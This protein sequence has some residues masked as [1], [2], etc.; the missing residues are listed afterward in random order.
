LVN[1]RAIIF[2]MDGLLLDSERI[3]LN[4]FVEACRAH[5]FEPDLKVYY[6]CI[7]TVFAHTREILREGYGSEFPLESISAF[8]KNLYHEEITR[9]PVPLKQGAVELL[10]FLKIQKLPLAVVTSSRWQNAQMKLSMAGI[11]GY[12]TFILGGDQIS[13]GKP[14]PEI[15]LTACQRLNLEPARCLA[16]EDS[17]NGVRAAR[18]AGLHVIQV[19]D[20]LTPGEEIRNSGHTIVRSLVEVLDL[21]PG[22]LE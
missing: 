15:Y 12:F 7:G 19:P 22:V 18:S 14:D 21:L 4:T 17:D 9:K 16:L 5:G 11:A 10:D 20:I 6:R 3:S 13:Q 1:I 8:W 2:D